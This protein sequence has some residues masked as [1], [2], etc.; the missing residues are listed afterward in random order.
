MYGKNF[1]LYDKLA[2]GVFPLC[3]PYVNKVIRNLFTHFGRYVCDRKWCAGNPLV[4][5]SP[6]LKAPSIFEI[7]KTQANRILQNIRANQKFA[8]DENS[9][10]SISDV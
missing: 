9:E 7:F 8:H 4:C 6:K 5:D 10:G 1:G 2:M 3:V